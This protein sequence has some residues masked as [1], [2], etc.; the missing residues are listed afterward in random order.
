MTKARQQD[1]TERIPFGVAKKKMN[2]DPVTTQKLKSRGLRPRW[3]NDE[4][5]GNRLAEAQR[6]GYEFIE[7]DGS[8]ALGDSKEAQEQNKRIRKLVGSNKDGSAKYAYLMAIKEEWYQEDQQL[9]EERNARVDEAVMGGRPQ[10]TQPHNIPRESG[11]TY[12]KNIEY[13]P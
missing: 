3:I 12:V 11:G 5:H 1:R 4:D 13:Q 7:S 10:G 8:E 9:K 2:L 6:G